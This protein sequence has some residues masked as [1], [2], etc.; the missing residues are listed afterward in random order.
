MSLACA[1]MGGAMEIPLGLVPDLEKL[2]KT[3]TVS[4]QPMGADEPVEVVSY[5]LSSIS[6]SVP[7]QFGI[8]YCRQHG[9]DWEDATSPGHVEVSWPKIPSPRDYQIEPLDQIEETFE[10]YYDF[11]FRARTGWGKTIGSLIWAARYACPVLITVDQD[12]LKQQ[13]VDTL[14]KHFGFKVSDIGIIQ[15]DKC[16]YEGKTVTIAMAQTI[17]KRL[18]AGARDY[19]G[20]LIVDEVHTIGAPTFH[21]ILQEISAGRRLGV[22]ATPRRRDSL[23]KLIEWNL[24]GVRLWIAD[25]HEPSAVYVMRHDGV[26]SEYANKAP[27]I[28]RFINEVTEDAARNYALAEAITFLYDTGR[29]TLVLSDRIEHL[30]ELM[31]LCEYMGVPAEEMGVYAGYKLVYAYVKDET[32]LRRPE[33]YVRGTEYTPVKLSLISKR[34][35]NDHLEKVKTTARIIFAT[36]GKFSKGVD[37][38]RLNG[39]VDASPRSQSE[40]MQGRILRGGTDKTP[41][42]ITVRD[43]KS[44]RSLYALA[45]RIV[46][47][48]KNNAVISLWGLEDGKTVCNATDLRTEILDEVDRLKSLR[49]AMNSDGL[50]TLQTRAQQMR[51]GLRQGTATTAARVRPRA[52][53]TA[54]SSVG[55]PAR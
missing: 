31:V 51:Q 39:G 36:Y 6:I 37:E 32:P 45:Q 1:K 38:P 21:W 40:Q 48:T 42:W 8:A 14:V 7:R 29:N 35:K 26:Y 55:R 18:P 34:L 23:R 13:W 43:T 54:S 11:V 22:S 20:I 2:K 28:G 4:T 12:N 41:I 5:R 10:D 15:G 50:N 25:E 52:L 49:I 16:T 3:L 44:Y 17:R 27:K 33:G 30:N 9:I 47:Y 24:G 19:F 53:P 46:D